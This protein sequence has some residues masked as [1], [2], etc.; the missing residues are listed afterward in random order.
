MVKEKVADVV[1]IGGG[2]AGLNAALV[3]GRARRSVIVFDDQKPRNLPVSASHGFFTRDGAS[4]AELRRI[5][6][7]Q[8]KA[9]PSISF[10]PA[11]VTDV[12]KTHDQFQV[13]SDINKVI[14][15][16]KILFATGLKEKL[17]DIKGLKELYGKSVFPC[18]YCDGWELRDQPLAI[19]AK[20]QHA[21]HLSQVLTGWSRDLVIC[22]NG[23]SGLNKA[24]RS[25][26]Q[27]LNISI[28]ENR[29]SHLQAEGDQLKA[30]VF[31]NGQQIQRKAIFLNTHLQQ[32]TTLPKK[33]G[34][35]VSYHERLQMEFF[36]TNE[37]NETN[38]PG[39]FVA[40]DAM[41]L[42]LAQIGIAAADGSTAAIG[43]NNQLIFENLELELKERG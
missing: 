1:I 15:A 27:R 22:S 24:E 4:P 14:W 21:L 9:Y 2:P 13:F 16:K 17:P 42:A 33:L 6:R 40:G 26:L 8:L 7:E 19:L 30:I 39:V 12:V 32:A 36:H 34:C 41:K 37:W 35:S 5:G 31:Q 20:E 10:V 18:P 28:M 25:R 3:L 29:I 43:I 23:P 38:V 11:R